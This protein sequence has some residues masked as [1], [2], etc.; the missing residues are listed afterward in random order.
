M[1][2]NCNCDGYDKCSIVGYL[3]FGFCCSHCF[4]YN[5]SHTC[6]STK[7]KHLEE[8]SIEGSFLRVVIENKGEEIPIDIDLKKHLENKEIQ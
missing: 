7:T 3:P 4:L 5:E 1:C 8:D 6:L 2:N